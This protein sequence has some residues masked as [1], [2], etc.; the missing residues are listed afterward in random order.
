MP[1]ARH[2][3]LPEL[4][5]L[6][7]LFKPRCIYPNTI[8]PEAKGADY[9]S[10][11]SMFGNLLAP[12]GT[13]RLTNAA[14]EHAASLKVA[15]LYV[16]QTD[17]DQESQEDA[18]AREARAGK[19]A[20]L[21]GR[22]GKQFIADNFD[23]LE[24]LG[25]IDLLMLDDSAE[26]SRDA[27]PGPP[28]VPNN[29]R[30]PTRTASAGLSRGPSIISTSSHMIIEDAAALALP[31]TGSALKPSLEPPGSPRASTIAGR[32]SSSLAAVQSKAS[33]EKH[34]SSTRAMESPSTANEPSAAQSVLAGCAIYF[35]N[36]VAAGVQDLEKQIVSA[37]GVVIRSGECSSSQRT[38]IRLASFVLCEGRSSNVYNTARELGKA[39]VGQTWLARVLEYSILADPMQHI[40][41][42]PI[43]ANPPEGFSDMVSRSLTRKR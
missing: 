33:T 2:S 5:D 40:L 27:E 16:P 9:L 39:I 21:S 18:E 28:P 37:G 13:V 32:P 20:I 41:Y 35:D 8:Y 23:H 25:D 43:P 4:Q 24:D 31:R 3:T 12:G 29:L 1:L 38:A 26:P 42:H 6:V 15:A 19:F 22:V 17:D 36:P 34:Q 14:R 10:L 7:G 11:P 30:P